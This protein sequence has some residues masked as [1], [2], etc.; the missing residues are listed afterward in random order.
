MVYYPDFPR[1]WLL[2]SLGIESGAKRENPRDAAQAAEP[3]KFLK[4]GVGANFLPVPG[5]AAC[6]PRPGKEVFPH[7]KNDGQTKKS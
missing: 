1:A 7:E 6:K 2:G 4:R 5:A 3:I